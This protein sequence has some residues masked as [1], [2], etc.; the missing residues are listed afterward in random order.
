MPSAGCGGPTRAERRQI[1]INNPE[2]QGGQLNHSMA[3]RNAQYQQRRP[4]VA[5]SSRS[6]AEFHVVDVGEP[7]LEAGGAAAAVGE[8]LVLESFGDDGL[9]LRVGG[10][11]GLGVEEASGVDG[12]EVLG[13]QADASPS[14][15]LRWRAE[16]L[17]RARAAG[18][19]WL[20]LGE[21]DRGLDPG[22]W[23]PETLGS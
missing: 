22:F 4:S 13:D 7:H 16:L 18:R 19:L 12:W 6:E 5:R 8:V 15:L 9:E 10:A 14:S 1:L 2:H 3:N 23:T 20:R 21:A 17:G 11:G